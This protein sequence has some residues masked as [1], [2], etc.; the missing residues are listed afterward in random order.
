M[1]LQHEHSLLRQVRR[2]IALTIQGQM[3]EAPDLVK[4]AHHLLEVTNVEVIAAD[5]LTEKRLIWVTHLIIQDKHV[6]I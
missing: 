4:V 1:V 5:K 6:V 3:L 2:I